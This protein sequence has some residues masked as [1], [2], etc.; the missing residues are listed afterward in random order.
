MY[1]SVTAS[2]TLGYDRSE[3]LV[4][5]PLPLPSTGACS[6]HQLQLITYCTSFLCPFSCNH[7]QVWHVN[8]TIGKDPTSPPF[9]LSLVQTRSSLQRSQHHPLA[10]TGEVKTK[11]KDWK[12]KQDKVKQPMTIIIKEKLLQKSCCWFCGKKHLDRQRSWAQCL[13]KTLTLHL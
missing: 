11:K 9:T 2:V 4:L 7:T 3:T 8:D 12:E 10:Q 13:S 1:Q 5:P 6:S